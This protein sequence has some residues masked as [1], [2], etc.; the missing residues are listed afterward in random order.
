MFGT[1]RTY[2]ALAVMGQHLLGIPIIGRY[3]VVC[4]FILSGYLMTYIMHNSYGYS[5]SGVISFCANRAMRLYPTY[6]FVLLLSAIL[7]L[8][9]GNEAT[10]AYRSVIFMPESISEWLCN[11]FFVYPAVFPGKVTPRLSPPTWA[12]TVEL[13]Y[14]GVIA[15]GASRSK[16]A[17]NSYLIISVLYFTYTYIAGLGNEWRYSSIFAGSLAFSLGSVIYHHRGQ[18]IN[19][20][21]PLQKG[22]VISFLLVLFLLNPLCALIVETFWNLSVLDFSFYLNYLISF[23]TICLLIEGKIPYIRQEIDKFIGDYSYP[24]YLMHW[25]AGLLSS[26]LIF[27]EPIRG[28]SS[29]SVMSFLLALFIASAISS[30]CVFFIDRPIEAVRT[31]IKKRANKAKEATA[32]NR[33]SS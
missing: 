14:Y 32:C 28:L 22:S 31:R 24:L 3:A 25:Q 23:I 17:A 16:A 9:Y 19:L 33:A 21:R 2:L 10:Q 4:F 20:V 7:V 11:L 6:W 27:N 18:L 26:Y 15:I 29:R 5:R 1:Y 12:L 30:I 8:A 13:F